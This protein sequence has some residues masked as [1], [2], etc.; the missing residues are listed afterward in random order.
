MNDFDADEE[1][2]KQPYDVVIVGSGATGGWAA[3]VLCEGGLNVLVL[4]A[5]RPLNAASDFKPNYWS[6]LTD[7]KPADVSRQL[8]QSRHPIF[9]AANRHFFADDID[10]PYETPARKPFVWIRGHQEGGR[11]MVWGG[12]TWRISDFEFQAPERDGWGLSWPLQ[13]ADLAPF[14]SEVEQFLGVHGSQRG[15]PELPDGEFLNAHPITFAEAEFAR[16]VEATW[17]ERH[18]I[19]VRSISPTTPGEPHRDFAWPQ[20]TSPSSTL[21][22][23]KKTGRLRIRTHAAVSYITTSSGTGLAQSV[24]FIDTQSKKTY[25]VVAKAVVL[26][27]STLESTRILLNSRSKHAPNGLGN[28]SGTLGRYLMDHTCVSIDGVAAESKRDKDSGKSAY[29]G[30]P[31]GIY[32]PRFRNLEQQRSDYRRGFG[33]WGSIHRTLGPDANDARFLLVAIGEMLPYEDNIVTLSTTQKDIYG[34]PTLR[35]ECT[36]RENEER[37]AEDALT[38]LTEMATKAG[39]TIEND[40]PFMMTPGAFVHEVGTARMGTD[41]RSSVLNPYN[42]SWDVDNLY[43]MD[44]ACWTTGAY[45]NPTLTM[46]AITVRACRELLKR[47][48]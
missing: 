31:Y 28:S 33:V 43:V 4:E 9:N 46:M 47:A 39:H 35:I 24:V 27:A 26:C 32:I 23:A 16:I 2:L 15:L 34:I 25:E 3:K 30:G 37:M 22:A 13:Y 41:A 1:H 11:S 36:H 14:Y 12:Q 8:M 7:A 45:Q 20:F 29:F 42:Q 10:H 17:P 21:A 6:R 38:C 48:L 40:Y 44:G 5:G 18:V 19:P